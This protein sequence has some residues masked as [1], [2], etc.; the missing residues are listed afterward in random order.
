ML[1]SEHRDQ[2]EGQQYLTDEFII[3]TSEKR[4]KILSNV[5]TPY[6]NILFSDN[7]RIQY[8]LDLVKIRIA[9]SS[10]SIDLDDAYNAIKLLEDD[11]E[12][13]VGNTFGPIPETWTSEMIVQLIDSIKI[14]QKSKTINASNVY[15]AI[16]HMLRS[17]SPAAAP[18]GFLERILSY[19]IYNPLA[20]FSQAGSD[21]QCHRSTVKD[22]YEQLQK[23][24]RIM[25]LG[26]LNGCH[27]G[28][29]PFTVFFEMADE[30]EWSL[31]RDSILSFPFTKTLHRVTTSP[32]GFVSFAIPGSKRN[33]SVF[34]SGIEKVS[35]EFFRYSSI[36]AP[37]ALTRMVNPSL[38]NDGKW[39]L[40]E[41]FSTREFKSP[42]EYSPAVSSLTCS[43]YIDEL[44]KDDFFISEIVA[45][46]L[47]KSAKEIAEIMKSRGYP[48]RSSQIAY[49]TRKLIQ[50][51]VMDPWLWYS[52]IGLHYNL[53]IEI[54][55][56]SS[57]REKIFQAVSGF[58]EVFTSA[59]DRGAIV[60]LDIPQYHLSYYYSFLADASRLDGVERIRPILAVVRSGGKNYIDI[61]EHLD[62]GERGFSD[63]SNDVDLAAHLQL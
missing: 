31:I 27:F 52:G 39:N 59:T 42:E 45:Y 38:M 23:L 19:F 14:L 22:G 2:T 43:G 9:L 44:T 62:F 5:V 10:G 60:W 32:F 13:V 47:R 21:L 11:P 6:D 16:I 63:A 54:A 53:A 8:Y 34:R 35:R 18:R 56:S 20:S 4:K 29:K 51:G 25:V 24:H 36:H 12:F 57:S 33:Q 50:L 48:F 30:D 26:M 28:I 41:Y 61:Y 37:R 49:R 58:P 46:H 55:S 15:S 3:Q 1:T 17:A 40:P 7:P